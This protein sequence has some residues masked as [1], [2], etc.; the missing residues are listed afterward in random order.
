MGKVSCNIIEDL[1]PLYYDQVCS[2]ESKQL[3]E[4][5]LLTCD[6]CKK[7]LESMGAD[8]GPPMSQVKKNKDDSKA[9]EKMADTWRKGR[10]YSF[11][12]GGIFGISLIGLVLLGYFGLFYWDVIKVPTEAVE[13]SD[14]SV[15]E[16]GKI[17]Y[18]AK[19]TDGYKLNRLKYDLDSK[20]NFY[21]TPLRPV[22]KEEA[23]DQ[24]IQT[25][26]NGYD[27]VDIEE[28]ELI[29]DR[30]IKK[31]FYGHP[32]DEILIWEEGMELPEASE[33]V[34]KYFGW[35]KE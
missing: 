24:P 7:K 31:I 27:F 17:V 6:D 2:D 19:I 35:S 28:Q 15:M 26:E 5:H 20:G 18:H 22:F 11:L 29:R 21:I 33:E 16:D 10:F 8:I 12:K 9:I 14:V 13:I 34:Y 4:E 3:V 1:L 30:D 32:G 23:V 25:L